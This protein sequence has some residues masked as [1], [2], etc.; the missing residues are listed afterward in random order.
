MP[1]LK[2][3]FAPI[4]YVRGPALKSAHDRNTVGR[5]ADPG[6]V[7]AD[8]VSR[9]IVEDELSEVRILRYKPEAGRYLVQVETSHSGDVMEISILF[10]QFLLT[11]CAGCK[12]NRPGLVSRQTH[13]GRNL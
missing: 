2:T 4:L 8:F 11:S 7:D 5:A 9:S 1:E 6:Q 13:L 3:S 10:C 12:L